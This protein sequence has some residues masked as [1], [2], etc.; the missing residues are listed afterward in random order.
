AVRRQEHDRARRR[1][2]RRQTLDVQ[3][4]CPP[5]RHHQDVRD[6]PRRRGHRGG[7]RSLRRAAAGRAH[8]RR[9]PARARAAEARGRREAEILMAP[10]KRVRTGVL[11]VA[12]EDSGPPDGAPVILLHGWPYDPRD[13]DQVVPALVAAGCRAIVPYLRGYGPTRFLS[14][15]TPRSGQQ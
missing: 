6:L 15:A 14:A 9:L 13:Y 3:G 1:Q 2:A 11:D 12:Y 8:L 4:L 7:F 5:P 10:L